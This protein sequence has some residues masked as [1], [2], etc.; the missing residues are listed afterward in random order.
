MA[1]LPLSSNC[2]Q[3]QVMIHFLMPRLA[4]VATIGIA[5]ESFLEDQFHLAVSRYVGRWLLQVEPIS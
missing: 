1:R 5:V 2:L 4:L 3:L